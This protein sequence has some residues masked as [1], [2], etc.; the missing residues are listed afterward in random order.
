[1]RL[2][3]FRAV[4]ITSLVMADPAFISPA[5]AQYASEAI[6]GSAFR[7]AAVGAAVGVAAAFMLFPPAT[8]PAWGALLSSQVLSGGAIGAMLGFFGGAL[9][10]QPAATIHGL[11]AIRGG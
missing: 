8:G 6:L 5:S 11:P 7:G 1:M 2:R 3:I 9:T 4:I 10:T